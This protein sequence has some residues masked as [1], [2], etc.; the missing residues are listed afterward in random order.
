MFQYCNGIVKMN[1]H[2][3]LYQY[4]LYVGIQLL[5]FKSIIII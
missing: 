1:Q 4:I 5:L 3:E 2:E